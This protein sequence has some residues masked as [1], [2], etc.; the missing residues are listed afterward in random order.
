MKTECTIFL[1]S[2]LQDENKNGRIAD[3]FVIRLVRIGDQ[4]SDTWWKSSLFAVPK[5]IDHMEEALLRQD[6]ERV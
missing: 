4:S 6:W 1:L 2:L 5:T 3:M